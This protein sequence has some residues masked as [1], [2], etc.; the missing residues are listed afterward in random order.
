[1]ILGLFTELATIGGM[2]RACMH[3]AAVLTEFASCREMQCQFLSL[4][5]S[6]KLH[7][8]SVAGRKFVCNGYAGDKLGFVGPAVHTAWGQPSL[9]VAGYPD[10][11]PLVAFANALA[12]KTKTIVIAHGVEVWKPLP[13]LKRLALR[14]VDLVLTPTWNTANQVA[15]HQGVSEEHIRVLPWALDPDF[16]ALIPA[17]SGPALPPGFPRGRVILT[18]GRWSGARYKGVDT[19]IVVLSRLLSRWA[20]LQLVV[21]GVGKDQAWFEQIADECGVR[22]HVHFLSGT[23][24]AEIAACYSACGYSRCQA[25]AK[26]LGSYT[27][28][29]W[30]VGSQ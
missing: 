26:D 8:M 18:V 29:R 28:K 21:A 20:D 3:V 14:K 19:L 9:V 27:S 22:R 11:G 4:N 17:V 13:L 16:A 6:H 24:Y 10:L 25:G 15:L 12:P 5:D 1:M 23:S 30:H 7:R 2:Q